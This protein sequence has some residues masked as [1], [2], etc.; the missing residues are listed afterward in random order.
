MNSTPSVVVERWNSESLWLAL[1]VLS[2]IALW[3]VLFLS[4]IGIFY[5]IFFG[6]FFFITHLAFIAHIRGSAVKISSEQFPELYST[7]NELSMKIGL[8]PVP[9]AYLM[10]QGGA[11][12]AFATKLFRSNIIVLYSD[13]L[14]ACGDNTTARNMIIGHELGHI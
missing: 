9:D 5:A 10:Q 4:A 13:L 11:L 3:I 12:N 14:E 7:I 6:V 1:V 2:S 8:E